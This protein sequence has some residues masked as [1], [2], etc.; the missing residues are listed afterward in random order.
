MWEVGKVKFT[1][2]D[3][4]L[5]TLDVSHTLLLDQMLGCSPKKDVGTVEEYTH[6]CTLTHSHINLSLAPQGAHRFLFVCLS[7]S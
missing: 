1:V 2:M 7:I 5:L 6:A 4:L 3:Y